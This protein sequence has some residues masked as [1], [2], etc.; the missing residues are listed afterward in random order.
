MFGHRAMLDDVWS[1]NISRLSRALFSFCT[2]GPTLPKIRFVEIHGQ[3]IAKPTVQV[4]VTR[5]GRELFQNEWIFLTTKAR[6]TTNDLVCQNHYMLTSYCR[7]YVVSVK[8]P[9]RGATKAQA[10]A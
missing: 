3:V 7:Y 8:R 1:P 9:D 2:S 5:R 4:L 10:L 6:A